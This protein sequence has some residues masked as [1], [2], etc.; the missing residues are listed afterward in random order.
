[1]YLFFSTVSTGID[2][3]KYIQ[4]YTAL[5][6]NTTLNFKTSCAFCTENSIFTKIEQTMS[7]QSIQIY[8]LELIKCHN[9]AFGTNNDKSYNVSNEE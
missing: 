7:D 3:A 2:I 8:K 4:N 1:M 5:Y 9:L 6:S